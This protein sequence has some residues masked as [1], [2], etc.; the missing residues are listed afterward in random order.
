MVGKGGGGAGLSLGG[1]ETGR[2][3]STA[4]SWAVKVTLLQW[5]AAQSLTPLC[6]PSSYSPPHCLLSGCSVLPAPQEFFFSSESLSRLYT[7]QQFCFNWES[8]IL[9]SVLSESINYMY[10]VCVAQL[11]SFAYLMLN[12]LSR[13][14]SEQKTPYPL[15][16]NNLV[17]GL[18]ILKNDS[19]VTNATRKCHVIASDKVRGGMSFVWLIS[20]SPGVYMN[21]S[22]QTQLLQIPL[23]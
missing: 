10:H 18:P 16:H 23:T 6:Q 20:D 4:D 7:L 21:D 11:H 5:Q 3:L 1:W 14:I 19:V 22:F 2:L 8:H 15:Y 12:E 9:L 13:D 17:C